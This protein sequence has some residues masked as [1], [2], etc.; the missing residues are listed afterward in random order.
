M[1]CTWRHKSGLGSFLLLALF[2]ISANVEGQIF[3]VTAGNAVD[4][5]ASWAE[6]TTAAIGPGQSRACPNGRLFFAN[7]YAVLATELNGQAVVWA[8]PAESPNPRIF[9]YSETAPPHVIYDN[10]I[11]KLKDNSLVF[12]TEAVTWNDNVNPKPGWWNQT[13]DYPL[14]EKKIPGGRGII[15]VYRSVDCGRTWTRAT[16]IDAA[17]L[18]V[19]GPT[20]LSLKGLCGAPRLKKGFKKVTVDLGNGPVE[21]TLPAQWSEA[22][23]WDGHFLYA[24]PYNGNL[25]L[26]TPCFY[27]A[28][29]V[30]EENR[31]ALLLMS[32]DRG[33]SW[34]VIRRIDMQKESVF[35]W[36]MPITSLP[37][38]Q[39]AFAYLSGSALKLLVAS[40]PY[41]QIN[42]QNPK[43]LTT[44]SSGGFAPGTDIRAHIKAYPSLARNP[45]KGFLASTSDW[46]AVDTGTKLIHRLFD[47]SAP[48]GAV[49]PLAKAIEAPEI[50]DVVHG[51][52]IDGMP[53]T[54]LHAVY[55]VERTP[56]PMA[57]TG[58]QLPNQFRVKFQV[59][60]GSKEL[61]KQPGELTIAG[62]Q[63]YTYLP[64][65]V[66]PENKMAFFVG[67][68][69]GGTSYADRN[70]NQH[71][72]AAWSEQGRLRFN[73][74][75]LTPQV[76]TVQV[77]TA[78][79]VQI[80]PQAVPRQRIVTAVPPDAG[81][82]PA[83]LGQQQE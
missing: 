37:T 54:D 31:L 62:G 16:D 41:S 48:G 4:L 57:A 22:G 83:I 67:D 24:D 25:F 13:Q 33:D 39:I 70:G 5:G 46:K 51:T 69:M 61:L 23:G 63:P 27:G 78:V 68:Y 71:F 35:A 2:L 50:S 7:G 53:N 10:H 43:I 11:V 47:V 14:K 3:K 40:A 59:Y 76:L 73:T 80:V 64:G 26:S 74:I 1:A 58:K 32:P 8:N 65:P 19:V 79:D 20:G 29:K 44:L 15:Y 12:T 36:R 56:G 45:G 75:T 77:P 30:N 52:F 49:Q 6:I 28:G 42:F 82:E 18:E 9:Q 55:W 60:K 34:K 66:I 38:G 72:V 81:P 17:K 21:Q